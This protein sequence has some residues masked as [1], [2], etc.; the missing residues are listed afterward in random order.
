ML[1]QEAFSKV[2]SFPGRGLFRATEA[3]TTGGTFGD[4]GGFKIPVNPVHAEI[5]FP[6]LTRIGIP[7]RNPPGT[8][9]HAGLAANTQRFVN[10]D[11]AILGPSLHGPGG[12][13]IHTPWF[14]TVE[15]GHVDKIQDRK[16]ILHLRPY[17]DNF[18]EESTLSRIVLGLA[19]NLAGLATDTLLQILGYTIFTHRYFLLLCLRFHGHKTFI[20]G[21]A[22]SCLVPTLQPAFHKGLIG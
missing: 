13:G 8:S 1:S 6:D 22:A 10:K 2:L 12:T 7:L 15:T 14:F 17:F 5:A 9:S 19:M 11:D 21:Q 3:E 20:Q 18:A 4:T 16:V